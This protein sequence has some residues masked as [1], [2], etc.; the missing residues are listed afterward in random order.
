MF[1]LTCMRRTTCKRKTCVHTWMLLFTFVSYSQAEY[2]RHF[3]EAWLIPK[4]RG[5]PI[6][7][8][9]QGNIHSKHIHSC[10]FWPLQSA[11]LTFK[12][13][14]GLMRICSLSHWFSATFTK[15]PYLSSVGTE[16][17]C[18]YF[19]YW[20]ISYERS[21]FMH[22]CPTFQSNTKFEGICFYTNKL[23][24]CRRDSDQTELFS[25]CGIFLHLQHVTSLFVLFAVW[26]LADQ[27]LHVERTNQDSLIIVLYNFNKLPDCRQFI[28]CPTRDENILDHR[29]PT[30][31]LDSVSPST[32][33][34]CVV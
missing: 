5:K 21:L 31:Q 29:T 11:L 27:I 4:D 33:M 12:S 20:W 28:K 9:V 18:I 14:C 30:K 7:L 15:A 22:V 34:H 25:W 16:I 2:R 24:V 8:N 26:T 13:H 10:Q 1:S 17:I 23:L 6:L 3:K 19:P 32:R